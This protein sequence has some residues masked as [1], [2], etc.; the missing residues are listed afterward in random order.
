MALTD[1]YLEDALATSLLRY[2]ERL[3]EAQ[4]LLAVL[5]EGWGEDDTR[6]GSRLAIRGLT[7]SAR[8]WLTAWLHRSLGGTLLLVTSHGDGYDELRDDLEY[9]R[10][11]GDVLAFPEPDVLPYDTVSPHPVIT[12]Q[13][14]ETLARLAAGATGIVL[15]TARG[16]L[17]RVPR[18]DRMRRD[19]VKLRVGSDM[20]PHQLIER[21][22]GLGYERFPEV[23][24]MGQIARRGGILDIYAA[25]SPDP[26]RLEFDGDTIASIRRFDAGTQRSLEP[27]S[28]AAV[29]P[30]HETTAPSETGGLTDYLPPDTLV[31]LDDPG[32]LRER[33]EDLEALIERGFEEGRKH[34]PDVE[35]PA[36]LFLPGRVLDDLAAS[37]RGADFLDAV[38][39]RGEAGRY[40]ETLVVDCRPAEPMQR[41]LERL[42]GH[43]T[44]LGANDIHPVVLCDNTGQRDRLLELL[45]DTG[46]TLG[47][48]LVAA[49]FTL[50]AAGLAVLTDHEVFARLRRRRRKLRRTGGLSIAELSALKV[51]DFVVHEDHGVGVYRGM[52]RLTLNG[53]ETDC[54]EISYAE[55]D[56]LFVPVAQLALVSR[57][58]AGEGARPAL[59]RLGSGSWAKTKARAQKAIQDMAENLIKTYAARKALPGHAFKEDTV[60]QREME[61]SFPYDETPDQMKAIEEVKA[62]MQRSS[63]M[64][65]L[66]CGDVGYGK[67]EVAIRA[68]FK[69]VQEGRQVGV[70]VP[71]TILAQQHL[72]TFRDRCA[73]FPVRIEVLSRFRTAKEIKTTLAALERGEVDVLI[74][75]HRLLS[76]DVKFKNLGLVIID[77]EHRFGVAQKEKLRQL[78]RQVD[79]SGWCCCT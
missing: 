34:Y 12:A 25:G 64:D 78:V 14:Q 40:T 71:T 11:S 5:G 48:G 31:L 24:A 16:L 63:P 50:P 49:G 44:E 45:G 30:R 1:T 29:L 60:W 7:G 20:D 70:L 69:A 4:R 56:R 46:A 33:I 72:L 35:T 52:Q 37:H 68:A 23:E 66:I 76:K 3:P 43:L 41:S 22:V 32:R 15:A 75:T 65:R 59:H 57:Y 55:K 8:G 28:E 19:I 13:R 36:E 39:E 47:V 42:K 79:R 77:E 21:L 18:P 54:V 53:Q 51:G 67:T 74:G 58:S 38:I 9:F 62:D 6:A 10:G 27:L 2:A 17:Q 61:A 73:D 26:L